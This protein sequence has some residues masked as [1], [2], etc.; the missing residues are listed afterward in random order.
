M[1]CSKCLDNQ[2]RT[3]HTPRIYAESRQPLRFDA[4]SLELPTAPPPIPPLMCPHQLSTDQLLQV[5]APVA[6]FVLDRLAE[7]GVLDI[8]SI[9]TELMKKCQARALFDVHKATINLLAG[10]YDDESLVPAAHSEKPI[11]WESLPGVT[12]NPDFSGYTAAPYCTDAPEHGYCLYSRDG[13]GTWN[14]RTKTVLPPAGYKAH[15]VFINGKWW[16]SYEGKV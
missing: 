11:E 7:R 3:G 8:L 10:T 15:P 4:E 5:L 1:I 9:R 13:R 14:Q 16:W 6:L 2:E 12:F